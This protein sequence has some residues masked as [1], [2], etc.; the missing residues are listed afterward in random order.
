[1]VRLLCHQGLLLTVLQLPRYC[2]RYIEWSKAFSAR[3]NSRGLS[4]DVCA[5]EAFSY[6]GFKYN[7]LRLCSLRRKRQAL[8][9]VLRH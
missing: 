9:T 8:C 5:V 4:G 2:S 6:T 7:L 3:S 1:M